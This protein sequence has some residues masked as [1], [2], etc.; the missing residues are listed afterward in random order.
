[1]HRVR[2]TIEKSALEGKPWP[3]QF[4]R[5]EILGSP[6]YAVTEFGGA[7]EKVGKPDG[8]KVE[9]G[10][11][12]RAVIIGANEIFPQAIRPVGTSINLPNQLSPSIFCDLQSGCVLRLYASVP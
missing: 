10:P 1:M 9:I 7:V 6:Q 2:R 8:L 3:V 12:R 5:G 4:I 11:K